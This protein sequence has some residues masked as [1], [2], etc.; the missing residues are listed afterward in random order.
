MPEVSFGLKFANNLKVFAIN[1]IPKPVISHA[2]I[3]PPALAEA[4]MV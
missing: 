3:T 4:V 1:Q 2:N